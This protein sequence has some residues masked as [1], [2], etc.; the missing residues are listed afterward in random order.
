MFSSLAD[1]DITFKMFDT[2]V[3]KGKVHKKKEKKKLTNVSFMYVHVQGV[4]KKM[5]FNE[6]GTQ[7]A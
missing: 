6:I 7:G 2:F 5:L 3:F 4:S 1:L